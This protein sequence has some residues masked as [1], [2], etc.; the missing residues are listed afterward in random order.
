[1]DTW[2]AWLVNSFRVPAEADEVVSSRDDG[3]FDL[4]KHPWIYCP[5][6]YQVMLNG[7]SWLGATSIGAQQSI[8]A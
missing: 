2:L 5:W 8:V 4:V 6:S 7:L 3:L 1:M